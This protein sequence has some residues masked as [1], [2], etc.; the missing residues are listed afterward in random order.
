MATVGGADSSV[1]SWDLWS[2]SEANAGTE[3]MYNNSYRYKNVGDNSRIIQTGAQGGHYTTEVHSGD[4]QYG[5]WNGSEASAAV[6]A[7]QVGG[8]AALNDGNGTYMA[9][10]GAAE[11]SVKVTASAYD[12][13]WYYSG[14]ASATASAEQ[15]QQHSYKQFANNGAGQRQWAVGTVGTYNNASVHV[16]D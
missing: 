5:W 1:S 8:T 12:G 9:G 14:D 2:S 15:G 3:A 6:T 4:S 16:S 13:S 10:G 11:G 7:Q